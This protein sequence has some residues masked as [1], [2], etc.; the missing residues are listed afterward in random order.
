MP[1]TTPNST[2]SSSEIIKALVLRHGQHD[3]IC[4]GV[5]QRN[6]YGEFHLRQNFVD[7]ID[8]VARVIEDYYVL[9]DV[10]AIWS[11]L[12]KLQA[13]AT[14]RSKETVEAYTNILIDIDR[15]VKTDAQNN[16][17]N[18]AE[19]E[20]EVLLR[21]ANR[22]AAFLREGEYGWG[23]GVIA[24]SGNGFHLEY[25]TAAF[26]PKTGKDLY[27]AVLAVLKA[28]FEATDVNLE[29]DLSVTN[30]TRVITAGADLTK[31]LIIS[32]VNGVDAEGNPFRRPFNLTDD[33]TLLEKA[34][35]ENPDIA[36]V[37][38]DPIAS[39]WGKKDSNKDD[40]MRPVMESLKEK[41]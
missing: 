37:A 4:V 1:E 26:D 8:A 6:G 15:S 5:Y 40:D 10:G 13:G 16:K 9:P 29:I 25:A 27:S 39:F 17:I 35:R 30:E 33:L 7:G 11:N 34:L 38:L 24:D 20:R 21:T 23:R 18:A 31:V 3:R 28:K 32:K 41:R 36:L 22:I 2:A 12:Q 14:S 19:A